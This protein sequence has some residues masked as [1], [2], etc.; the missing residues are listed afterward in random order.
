MVTLQAAHRDYDTEV[1]RGA[2]SCNVQEFSWYP[3]R[4]HDLA[5]P[6]QMQINGAAQHAED[7]QMNFPHEVKEW[8]DGQIYTYYANIL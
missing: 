5:S 1:Q 3:F 6:I 7:L 8:M 4:E 2:V